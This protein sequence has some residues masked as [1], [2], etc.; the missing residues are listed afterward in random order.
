M[1]AGHSQLPSSLYIV[2][3]ELLKGQ[4]EERVP[5]ECFPLKL[6]FNRRVST[7][8]VPRWRERQVPSSPV[9]RTH[10]VPLSL[11]CNSHLLPGCLCGG[12][13]SCNRD[14]VNASL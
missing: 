12:A 14:R 3:R 10:P 8:A 4:E 2:K 13:L 7:L 1:C 11:C 5:A 6:M 9:P